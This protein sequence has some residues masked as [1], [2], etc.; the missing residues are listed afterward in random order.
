MDISDLYLDTTGG[1]H[2]VLQDRVSEKWLHYRKAHVDSDWTITP[3]DT[4]LMQGLNWI[5]LTEIESTL[6]YIMFSWGKVGLMNSNAENLVKLDLESPI[7]ERQVEGI[8]P[9]VA[10][11]RTG[12]SAES[13]FVDILLL[14]GSSDAYPNG[15]NYYL[16]ISKDYILQELQ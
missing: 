8:Y 6:Y 5:R 11:P 9:Y 10:S 13:E 7:G 3:I 16:K 4:G 15:S 14:N 1:I 2:V 12:T